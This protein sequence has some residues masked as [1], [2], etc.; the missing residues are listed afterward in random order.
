MKK[1]NTMKNTSSEIIL[2][3]L[4][5]SKNV[6][7]KVINTHFLSVKVNNNNTQVADFYFWRELEYAVTKTFSLKVKIMFVPR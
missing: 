5:P 6:T 1:E 4:Q 3:K 2:S 7:V